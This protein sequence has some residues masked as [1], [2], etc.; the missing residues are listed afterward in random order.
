MSAL[1]EKLFQAIPENNIRLGY[2]VCRIEKIGTEALVSVGELEKEAWQQFRADRIIL[3]MPP[4]LAAATIFFEPELSHNLTQ[5]MMR[6][7]TWMAGQAKFCALYEEPFWR[8]IGLSGQAFSEQGPDGRTSIWNGIIH[9][10]GSETADNHGGY[11]EGA[12]SAAERA[13]MS[14]TQMS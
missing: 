6:I 11:L 13:V 2:P 12:M 10:A 7:S 4:R 8:R 14:V 3:A 9:F 1:V 5:A